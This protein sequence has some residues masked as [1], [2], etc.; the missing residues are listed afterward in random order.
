MSDDQDGMGVSGWGVCV[1]VCDVFRLSLRMPT[2]P[3]DECGPGELVLMAAAATQ[4]VNN[5]SEAERVCVV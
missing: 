1:C 5:H 4:L 2:A 3:V